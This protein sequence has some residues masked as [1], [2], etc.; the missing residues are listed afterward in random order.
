MEPAFK[1]GDV[2][3]LTNAAHEEYHPGDITVYKVPGGGDIPIVHRIVEMHD[4]AS[5]NAIDGCVR[6]TILDLSLNAD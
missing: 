3:F 4:L 2:L 5:P 6:M 1:R